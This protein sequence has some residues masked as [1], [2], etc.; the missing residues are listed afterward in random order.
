LASATSI[1]K[2]RRSARWFF[3]V[4]GFICSMPTSRNSQLCYCHA[5]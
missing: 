5:P 4:C 1:F 2:L 3:A